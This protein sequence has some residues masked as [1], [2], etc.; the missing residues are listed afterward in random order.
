M[1]NLPKLN[2]AQVLTAIRDGVREAFWEA[3][4][5][6]TDMPTADILESIRQGVKDAVTELGG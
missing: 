2:A 5:N 1:D 4:R 3:I 6:G